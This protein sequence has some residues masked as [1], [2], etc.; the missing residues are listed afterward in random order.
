V[1]QTATGG[2]QVQAL[3]RGPSR[4]TGVG[5]RFRPAQTAGARLSE[6]LK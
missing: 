2:A 1:V 5:N 3:S 6:K 4:T